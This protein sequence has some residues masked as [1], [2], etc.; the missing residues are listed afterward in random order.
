MA[1]SI[2]KKPKETKPVETPESSLSEYNWDDLGSDRLAISRELKKELDS[3][4]LT[5]K[6]IN[7]TKLK[8]DYGFHKQGY[9]PYK[10]DNQ[11]IVGDIF[12]GDPEGYVRRGD[13]ILAVVPKSHADKAK[14]ALQIKTD[15]QANTSKLKA[16][17]LKE[18]MR[19]AGLSAVVDEGYGDDGEEGFG[20]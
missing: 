4:G 7:A 3:K 2:E 6:F 8:A 9:R 19:S 11:A 5:Y 16:Q 10:P 1:K 12:G 15:L 14:K 18:Q 13:L 20:V 17:E